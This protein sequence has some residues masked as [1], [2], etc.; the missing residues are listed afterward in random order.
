MIVDTRWPYEY[1]GGHIAT[2]L[3]IWSRQAIQ[4]YFFDPLLELHDSILIF[5]HCEFSTHRALALAA[6]LRNLDRQGNSYPKLSYPY[7]F[8][9]K[10]GYSNFY[11]KFKKQAELFDPEPVY[12]QMKHP[13]FHDECIHYSKDS[14]EIK[15]QQKGLKIENVNAHSSN[16][17]HFTLIDQNTQHLSRSMQDQLP[18]YSQLNL[19]ESIES[20]ASLSIEM[21]QMAVNKEDNKKKLNKRGYKN[22][23]RNQWG[24]E[25]QQ[26]QTVEQQQNINND[27][28]KNKKSDKRMKNKSEVKTDDNDL[29]QFLTNQSSSVST[30]EDV[31]QSNISPINTSNCDKISQKDN[32]QNS[33]NYNKQGELNKTP[34]SSKVFQQTSEQD[35]KN[36]VFTHPNEHESSHSQLLYPSQMNDESF[37]MPQPVHN[38]STSKTNQQLLQYQLQQQIQNSIMTPSLSR[39]VSPPYGF[40]TPSNSQQSLAKLE[41]QILKSVLSTPK[42][43]TALGISN[44]AS[45]VIYQFSS[46]MNSSSSQGRSHNK[47]VSSNKNKK[48]SN[49]KH[50]NP[51]ILI[52]TINSDA[53][54]DSS[55][56]P[57]ISPQDSLKA[58]DQNKL[59][60][61]TFALKYKALIIVTAHFPSAQKKIIDSLQ[62]YFQITKIETITDFII[63]FIP[64]IFIYT[65]YC[66]SQTGLSVTGSEVESDITRF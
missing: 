21:Q 38:T 19:T 5:F 18:S 56:S 26:Q 55:S 45:A 65:Y 29:D 23:M 3:N 9:I 16:R 66:T 59:G 22:L 20:S 43:H 44:E 7:V 46:L 24:N 64:F 53:Q 58:F 8:I 1:N 14:K 33:G 36:Q 48:E 4:K 27:N 12:I 52:P 2:A 57:I 47:K 50:D 37:C 30:Y 34:G 49:N 11:E 17:P 42:I 40:L 62:H 13:K 10:G 63:T 41:P 25:Q 32:N 39:D 35:H 60:F 54:R 31:E 15:K 28:H 6:H 61:Q 51:T